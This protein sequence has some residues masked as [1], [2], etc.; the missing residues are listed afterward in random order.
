MQFV[1]WNVGRRVS[2]RLEIGAD[3]ERFSRPARRFVDFGVVWIFGG[4]K[5][6]ADF[7]MVGGIG[8]II[9]GLCSRFRRGDWRQRN[10]RR[11]DGQTTAHGV[12]DGCL[13]SGE[14]G[15]RDGLVALCDGGGADY[16]CWRLRLDG[17]AALEMDCWRL[18]RAMKTEWLADLLALVARL[19]SGASVR[20]ESPRALGEGQR[21]YVANHSSHL[22]F[23]VLWAAL[24]TNLRR[25]TRP[26]AA[27]DYWEKT[28]LRRY[29][30]LRIYRAILIEREHVSAHNNPIDQIADAMG[31]GDS[32]ILFPE[33]TRGTGEEIGAFK[34]GIYHLAHR[35]PELECVPVYLEN[36]NRV[37]PK[38][39]FLPL[40]ILSR[41]A[42]GEPIQLEDGESKTAFLERLRAAVL[43]L[44]DE[45]KPCS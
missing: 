15:K 4:A 40:P 35:K 45:E 41:I 43:A 37:L 33:G 13:R 3:L 18:E 31:E 19:V 28:A 20:L 5:L 42:L 8:R 30:S 27:K 21:V 24:P 12:G 25:Q 17:R 32:V 26:V 6:V 22:D 34:S 14:F 29:L 16:G 1:R 11:A 38:G 10:L 39:E 36:L 2:T 7:G 44:G 9:D 23:I